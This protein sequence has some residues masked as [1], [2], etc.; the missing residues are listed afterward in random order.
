M[1]DLTISNTENTNVIHNSIILCV[2]IQI[3]NMIVIIIKPHIINVVFIHYKLIHNN[4]LKHYHIIVLK[5]EIIL[6]K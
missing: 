1:N 5:Y 6:K 3:Q 2:R 4:I